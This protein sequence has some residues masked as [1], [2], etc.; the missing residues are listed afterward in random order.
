MRT[1]QRRRMPTRRGS[2]W[3]LRALDVFGVVLAWACVLA[4]FGSIALEVYSRFRAH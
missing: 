4:V 3:G 1:N 2:P